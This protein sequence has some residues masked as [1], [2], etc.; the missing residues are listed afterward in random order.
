MKIAKNIQTPEP[1]QGPRIL[2]ADDDKFYLK[3]FQELIAELGYDCLTVENGLEALEK[4]RP[5]NPSLIISDVLMP[6]M[7]G[8]E[9]T[10]RLKDDPLTMHVPVLIV[11]SLSDRASKVKGL[12]AGASELLSKPIDENEFRIRVNNLLKVARYEGWLLEHGK[13]LEGEVVSKSA[14]LERALSTIRG[15]YIETVYRLTLAAEYRDKETGGHIKRIPL[16]SQLLARYMG[17]R[18][19]DAEAIFF[20]SPMHDIGKIGIPDAILLKNGRYTREEADVMKR[21]TL[22]GASILHASNSDILRTAEQI[23]LTHHESWDGTGYPMGLRGAEIPINGRI[24]NIVDIY[25]A[26]RSKRPYKEPYD[27]KAALDI[28]EDEK[29]RFDPAVLKAF[30]E[31]SDEFRRLFEEHQEGELIVGTNGA[32][33]A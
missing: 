30:R 22:I 3:I 27:H 16:Y 21:H 25:D 1:E 8:F 19:A 10:K 23:A 13:M 4:A 6:G 33:T 32:K 2:V 24:V 12:E 29:N 18:E 9:L 11:T 31:C 7:D 28:I 14:Q 15:A 26:L 17:L 20:A 5:Y